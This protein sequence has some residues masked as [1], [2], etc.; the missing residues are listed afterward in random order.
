MYL[1][2]IY[3]NSIA[4]KLIAITCLNVSSPR[5]EDVEIFQLNVQAVGLLF[6]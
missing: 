3:L 4:V 1:F 2:Q 6:E 5:L